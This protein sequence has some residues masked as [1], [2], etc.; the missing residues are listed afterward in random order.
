M[1]F[2]EDEPGLVKTQYF[3]RIFTLK[4]QTYLPGY[5]I[6]LRRVCLALFHMKEID[7]TLKNLSEPAHIPHAQDKGDQLILT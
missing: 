1:W 4:N 2:P 5:T 6:I 3:K 7:L